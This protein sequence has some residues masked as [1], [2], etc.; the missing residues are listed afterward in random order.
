MLN[1]ARVPW[2]FGGTWTVL[3]GMTRWPGTEDVQS[4]SDQSG[5]RTNGSGRMLRCSGDPAQGMA[6]IDHTSKSNILSFLQIF[7]PKRGAKFYQRIKAG[8]SLRTLIVL[9]FFRFCFSPNV[10]YLLHFHNYNWISSSDTR[11]VRSAIS[12]TVIPWTDRREGGTWSRK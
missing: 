4:W 3:V 2:S 9:V 8:L 11:A 7:F 6:T 12:V 1:P 10:T 5:S